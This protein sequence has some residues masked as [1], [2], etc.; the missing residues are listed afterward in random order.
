MSMP[1]IAADSPSLEPE[2]WLPFSVVG[3]WWDG[4]DFIPAERLG[5]WDGTE[6]RKVSV[7][8]WWDGNQVRPMTYPSKALV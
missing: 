4:A 7:L 8:G 6:I 5:W 1:W 3:E 2:K